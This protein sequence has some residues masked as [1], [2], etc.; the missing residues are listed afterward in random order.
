MH[1]LMD[2]TNLHF[3]LY[4]KNVCQN[5]ILCTLPAQPLSDLLDNNNFGVLEKDSA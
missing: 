4:K 2:E 3:F 5:R 1:M